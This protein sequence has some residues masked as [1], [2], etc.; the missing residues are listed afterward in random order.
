MGAML[1]LVFIVGILA[2]LDALMERSTEVTIANKYGLHARPAAEFVKLA[3][4]FA[5]E[6]WVRKDEWR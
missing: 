3:N 4:R 1:L 2:A 5:S 6:I